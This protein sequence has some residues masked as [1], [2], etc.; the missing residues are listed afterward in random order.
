ME[1][2]EEIKKKL[3]DDYKKRM[4]HYNNHCEILELEKKHF[5]AT[6]PDWPED[7]LEIMFLNVIAPPQKIILT[8]LK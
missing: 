2:F 3:D 4:W 8:E 6:H 7:L 1:N 5:I